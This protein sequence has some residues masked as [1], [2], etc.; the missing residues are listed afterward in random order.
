MK[1]PVFM[2]LAWFGFLLAE[3]SPMPGLP[4]PDFK[5]GAG[6]SDSVLAAA[7]QASGKIL[8]AGRFKTYDSRSQP[9]LAR[10][11][12]DGKIDTSFAP[13]S[14]QGA[15]AEITALLV[16]QDGRIVIGGTWTNISGFAF[17]NIA[18]LNADGVV[19]SSFNPGAG[20]NGQVFDILNYGRGPM[21]VMGEFTAFNK[22]PRNRLARIASNGELDL[23]FNPGSAANNRINT[24]ALQSDDKLVLGG[25]F[26]TFNNIPHPYVGRITSSG[27]LDTAFTAQTDGSVAAVAIQSDG[28]ILLGGTFTTANLVPATR[29]ARLLP[30]GKLDTN[31]V[32]TPG[33]SGEIFP[34]VPPIVKSIVLQPN[35]KILIAGRFTSAQGAPR[36]NIAR[37]LPDGSIDPSFNPGSGPAG[38]FPQLHQLLLQG[39]KVIVAGDFTSYNGTNWNR[40]ARAL[41]G[42]P[43]LPA[44]ATQP[45]N[46]GGAAGSTVTLSVAATGTDPLFYQWRKN[47]A[48]MRGQFNPALTL[49]NL[50]M[51]DAGQYQVVVTNAFGAITSQVAVV[52]VSIPAPVIAGQSVSSNVFQVFT[53]TTAGKSYL[54]EWKP[55]VTS[56]WSAV[57]ALLSGDNSI[58]SWRH[59]NELTSSSFYR[60]KME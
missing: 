57:G 45:Q 29:L 5:P 12:Q 26:T 3:G 35:G 19:D 15:G 55:S 4:D 30:N 50:K 22:I 14:I 52:T 9:F 21:L 17:T 23:A 40:I 34:G 56:N 13:I 28:K 42:E 53:P 1:V 7:L 36:K 8:V 2:F 10:L 33:V 18:M 54:L 44:I 51:T 6:A 16:R 27:Q 31:F 20:A 39:D 32:S 49:S 41:A 60:V 24:V 59:T 43:I 38:V 37:L 11:E 47:G 48:A 46:S 25:E 58:R